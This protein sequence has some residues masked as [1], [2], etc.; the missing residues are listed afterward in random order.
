MQFLSD[1]FLESYSNQKPNWGFHSG[2]NSLGEITYLRSY[3]Q[4]GEKWWQTIAR[5]VEETYQNIQ[6]HC[7][8]YNI[9]FD[10]DLARFDAENMYDLCFSFKM[11]PGGRGLW[12]M[13]TETVRTKGSMALN[14]CSAVSTADLDKDAIK[15]FVYMMDVSMLGVGCGF[16]CRGAGKVAWAGTG[17]TEEAFV[18]P[19]SREGWCESLG[20]L[21][22]WAF[23]LT[24]AKPVFDYSEIRA[25]GAPIKTF[26]GT[27]PGPQPL[28]D[29]HAALFEL[30]GRRIGEKI[31]STDITDIMNLIGVCVV[32]GGIRRTAQIVFG[33]FDD[34]EYISLKDYNKNPH[35]MAHGWASNNS[36]F[37]EPGQDYSKIVDRIADN[38]EPG[39]FWLGNAQA[40]GR[41][42]ESPNNADHRAILTNPCG[43]I[44]LES[45]ELCNLIETFP[46][47][48]T[49]LEDYKRTL[50]YALIYAKAVTLIPT[51]WTETNAV[52][53]R[54]RRIGV[55]M[56]GIAQFITRRGKR[57]LTHWASEGYK[58]LRK[59]DNIYSEWLC[60]RESIKLTTIK[61]SGSVSLL[62]GATPGVHY[63]TYKHYI[64]RMRLRDDSP[65]LKPLMDAGYYTEPAVNEPMTTIVEFPVAGDDDVPTERDVTVGEKISVS[66]L[67]QKYWAD[68][69]VSCTA[70]FDKDTEKDLLNDL[71]QAYDTQ[72]KA[73]SL[74]PLPEQ[75]SYEQMPYEPI[76]RERYEELVANIKPIVWED[77]DAHDTDI[78]FC[79]GDTCEI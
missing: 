57:D 55:S 36:V 69:Q 37:A 17:A 62:A 66:V 33:E 48:H 61:P 24:E 34:D 52:T 63:P 54:N 40:Y 45:Y 50:K 27:A 72:M 32:S 18:V 9:P 60:V 42:A 39:L 65:L 26:G 14:N 19:D 53:L 20:A 21:L 2:P 51:H 79:D 12:A 38:G 75:S 23:G 58:T 1:S 67:L 5:V 44:T 4:N 78:K 35:R 73:I 10:A 7:K 11:L 29:L 49:D 56:S 74:L 25:K 16:D 64:R 46:Q 15:P 30:A 28:M 13:G 31:T 70:T 3:S 43:E 77:T 22:S 68:N 71:L 47:N 59:Y 76:T 8:H 41:M 6:K